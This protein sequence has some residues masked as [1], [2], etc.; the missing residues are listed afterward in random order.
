MAQVSG[1]SRAV[2]SRVRARLLVAT[3]AIVGP[4]RAP[5]RALGVL[6]LGVLG[7]EPPPEGRRLVV[8]RVLLVV[9]GERQ[10]RLFAPG[11]ARVLRGHRRIG[12]V[13]GPLPGLDPRTGVVRF[14]GVRRSGA[15]G[16]EVEVG[17]SPAPQGQVGAGQAN[18]RQIGVFAA[19]N[20]GQVGL[21]VSRGVGVA[22]DPEE[23]QS[24]G[25]TPRGARALARRG[26]EGAQGGEASRGFARLLGGGVLA[27]EAIVGGGRRVVA[28]GRLLHLGELKQEPR[29][30]AGALAEGP[31]EGGHGACRFVR[32]APDFG[33]AG[34]G[35]TREGA[36]AFGAARGCEEGLRRGVR[37]LERL[38]GAAEAE[39]RVI[40]EQGLLDVRVS[41]EGDGVR[42]PVD[43]HEEETR[44]ELR[45]ARRHGARIPARNLAQAG[46]G[47]S[48]SGEPGSGG[49]RVTE[50]LL[51]R[52]VW[53]RLKPELTS[54]G[55]L[56]RDRGNRR[57]QEGKRSEEGEAHVT[58]ASF[59]LTWVRG[60]TRRRP[61]GSARARRRSS[62]WNRARRRP[63]DRST[64]GV[65]A[66]CLP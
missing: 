48:R 9:V 38:L 21:Q 59:E 45:E 43:V 4:G 31:L 42:R 53:G 24:L 66:R 15:Y 41:E 33:R 12:R 32:L 20:P 60:P 37:L 36:G 51:L 14:G 54:L 55:A 22:P 58:R 18:A 63:L 3:R 1:R 35:L 2:R 50:G 23:G 6:A 26:Q 56:G 62:S 65:R 16:R 7:Q 52:V 44:R 11:G 46:E 13:H 5:G 19:R 27:I 17:V 29:R 25:Q 8:A 49:E 30:G 34:Q 61:P 57:G 64:S 40:E 10:E 47:G 28:S 39:E